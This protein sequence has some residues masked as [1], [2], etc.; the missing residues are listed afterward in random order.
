MSGGCLGLR[1]DGGLQY[2]LEFRVFQIVAKGQ[3]ALEL[4]P[5]V[6]GLDGKLGVAKN[7]LP[8]TGK[9]VDLRSAE[10]NGAVARLQL[11]CL[12]DVRQC[13]AVMT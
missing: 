13:L 4:L 1:G 5:G 12:R 3:I 9:G 7:L 6:A 10:L 11:L 2:R 8:A